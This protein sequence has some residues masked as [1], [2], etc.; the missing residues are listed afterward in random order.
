[1]A[2]ERVVLRRRHSAQLK[3]SVLEQCAVPG[4]SVAKVAM[5]HGLNANVVHGWRKLARERAT[6]AE[7]RRM[8]DIVREA[9]MR[10]R[11]WRCYRSKS[12]F[13]RRSH[14]E[15]KSERLH[16]VFLTFARPAR[17]SAH[18][19]KGKFNQTRSGRSIPPCPPASAGP[20]K[21][22]LGYVREPMSR[23]KAKQSMGF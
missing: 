19:R 1:M 6:P 22:G 4:A 15:S 7:P 14:L 21:S 16:P 5:S 8:T 17:M 2:E 12:G 13:G 10:R 23:L 11:G 18:G 20:G 9:V 3:A